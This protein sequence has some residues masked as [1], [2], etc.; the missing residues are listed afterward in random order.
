M[1]R[2]GFVVILLIVFTGTICTG[3]QAD[4][5]EDLLNQGIGLYR[6]GNYTGALATFNRGLEIEPDNANLLWNASLVLTKLGRTK[7]AYETQWKAHSIDPQMIYLESESG[8]SQ[9]CAG[10]WENGVSYMN[11]SRYEEALFQFGRVA[12]LCPTDID[13]DIRHCYEARIYTA[14][15]R[16]DEAIASYREAILI[17]RDRLAREPDNIRYRWNYETATY[18]LNKLLSLQEAGNTTITSTTP[19][20]EVLQVTNTSIPVT[21]LPGRETADSAVTG[22]GVST[23]RTSEPITIRPVASAPATKASTSGWFAV[24][25]VI[26]PVLSL[27]RKRRK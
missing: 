10:Y 8:Y 5:V 23:P 16:T 15:G 22:S 21:S 4:T 18:N 11:K 26:I 13:T 20:Q 19:S 9:L 14:M 25:S 2:Y 1:V 3:V 6:F 12:E 24:C 7:E 27:S 17:M